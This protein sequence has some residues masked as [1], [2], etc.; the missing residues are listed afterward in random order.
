MTPRENR[1]QINISVGLQRFYGERFEKYDV[2]FEYNP[3]LLGWKPWQ[4]R[5][6]SELLE[7]FGRAL[8][9]FDATGYRSKYRLR[10]DINFALSALDIEGMYINGR[11][12]PTHLAYLPNEVQGF[13]GKSGILDDVRL[14]RGEFSRDLLF[15][16]IERR[17]KA[18]EN[19]QAE[20]GEFP[21]AT[22]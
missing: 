5:R 18:F 17:I 7:D 6:F 13:S 14:D 8:V 10:K 22:S 2:G 19:P 20:L 15:D 4:F 1:R 16:S 3:M 12:G 21:S 9:G 11:V